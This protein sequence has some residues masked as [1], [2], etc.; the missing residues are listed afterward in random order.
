MNKSARKIQAVFEAAADIENAKMPL[1]A[2]GNPLFKW[3]VMIG[4]FVC[5]INMFTLYARHWSAHAPPPY[6]YTI[7]NQGGYR[8]TVRG[9]YI[10]M[11]WVD[12]RMVFDDSE[13]PPARVSATAEAMAAVLAAVQLRDAVRS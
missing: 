9:N 2:E 6:N 1:D 4:D 7:T 11:R 13:H 5:P 3:K 12:Y 8:C 10:H